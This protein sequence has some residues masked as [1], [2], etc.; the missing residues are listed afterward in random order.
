MRKKK[1]N[2]KI[3]TATTKHRTTRIIKGKGKQKRHSWRVGLGGDRK[4]SSRLWHN[5]R[6]IGRGP[7][8]PGVF[9]C[10]DC[11][12][13]QWKDGEDQR[14]NNEKVGEEHEEQQ[15][16]YGPSAAATAV[17]AAG[18]NKKDQNKTKKTKNGLSTAAATAVAVAAA[19]AAA[20][21]GRGY[22]GGGSYACKMETCVNGKNAP[23]NTP[24]V[25]S[26]WANG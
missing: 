7:W 16:E 11:W 8:N 13:D 5:Q 19:A 12:A 2:R 26:I 9:F 23:C 24:M 18:Q 20:A 25:L 3:Y 15:E 1:G 21:G 17:A 10:D 6:T 22:G 14:K 4:N